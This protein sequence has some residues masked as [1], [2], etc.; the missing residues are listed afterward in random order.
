MIKIILADD[1]SIMRSGLKEILSKEPEFELIGE[2]VDGN[3]VLDLLR[4]KTPDLLLTD[5]S[6]PGIN[7]AELIERI[8]SLHPNLPVLVL[9][10]LNDA[11]TA[12]RI[13]KAGADG[14]LTK[15]SSPAQLIA[16]IHKV[17]ARGKCIDPKLA[18]QILFNTTSVEALHGNL[19]GRELD[20][21]KLLL[22]GLSVNSIA[23]KLCISNKTVSTHKNHLLEKMH[24]SNT[25]ELIRYAVQYDLFQD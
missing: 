16:A 3:E 2:A 6:M 22:Q 8:R 4:K 24:M 9:T 1:H 5:L 10:M 13:I 18:E 12:N 11:Q 20:V 21:Y 23:E 25:T 17:A 19:S 15:D 7:G 14:Y